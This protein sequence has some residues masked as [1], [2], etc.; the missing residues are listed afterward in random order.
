MWFVKDVLT[1]LG[2]KLLKCSSKSVN[3]KAT[4][5]DVRY[6]NLITGTKVKIHLFQSW[7]IL[8][9]SCV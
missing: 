5:L 6:Y 8:L 3:P 4:F 2:Q 7:Q 9:I 1:F